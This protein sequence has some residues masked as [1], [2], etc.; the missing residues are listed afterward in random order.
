MID[1]LFKIFKKTKQFPIIN[2]LFSVYR[3]FKMIFFKI[4]ITRIQARYNKIKDKI[5]DKEKI[6]IVFLLLNLDTWKYDSLYWAFLKNTKFIVNV[7]I[8]PVI[9]KGESF[10]LSDLQRSIAY[11]KN[12]GY[13]YTNAYIE[14]NKSLRNIKEELKPDIVF[15][16]NPNSLTN[17]EF[18]IDSFLDTLTCY[19][20]YSFRI[21]TLYNYGYN[22]KLVNLTWKNYY[23]SIFHL[24]I[25]KNY[26]TNKGRNVVISG[27]PH[28]DSFNKE[29]INVWKSQV[30]KKKKIVWGPHWTIKG[31][32]ETGLDWSCFLDYADFFIELAEKYKN[33]LQFALKPHPFL[34][35]LLEKDELWGKEKTANYFNLWETLENC[36]I[37]NGDY[38]N[39]FAESDALIHD[40]GAFMVEYLV[41]NKPV[42]YTLND[43]EPENSFNEFG[44]RAFKLHEVIKNQNQLEHFIKTVIDE[45]DTKRI[46][47]EEFVSNYLRKGSEKSSDNIVCDIIKSL[48]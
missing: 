4:K 1:Y 26:A 16:S 14:S 9:T 15:F 39:L 38:T 43:R 28:L 10:M 6:N 25:A 2:K 24:D 40:S 20:P 36:Q 46:D 32:Q 29:S 12:K 48:Q 44:K 3:F 7:V 8:C 33:D 37:V 11:C 17:Q 30:G 34:K 45:K 41:L 42:A 47:R 21:D 19:V 13:R 18:L 23:E 22:N 31:F 35:T 27:H 5:K